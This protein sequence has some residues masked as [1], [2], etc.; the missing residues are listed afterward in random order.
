MSSASHAAES[1][2]EAGTGRTQGRCQEIFFGVR[3]GLST[4][5]CKMLSLV[6]GKYMMNNGRIVADKQVVNRGGIY[7]M[8][9][10]GDK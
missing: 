8:K 4:L 10:T 7:A 1:E 6:E 5:R 2:S 9:R 3:C